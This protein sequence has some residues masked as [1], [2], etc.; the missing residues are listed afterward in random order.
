MQDITPKSLPSFRLLRRSFQILPGISAAKEAMLRSEGL[1]DWNDLLLRTPAQLHLFRKGGSAL[2]CA[3]EASEQ[4]LENRDVEFFTER[5]P[6]RE[7]YRIAASFPER[8]VF[9][10]IESTGLS[11]YYDQVT[12]VGW[13]RG[14][15]L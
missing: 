10:D 7:Y 1:Q 14:A 9:L 15:Q 6:K 11:R 8:C 5:L 2:R 13:V 3:V 4:A 12:L